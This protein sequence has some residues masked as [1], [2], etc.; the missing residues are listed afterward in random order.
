MKKC[1]SENHKRNRGAQTKE[2]ANYSNRLRCAELV[3]G[4]TVFGITEIALHIQL[5][6]AATEKF[7]SRAPPGVLKVAERKDLRS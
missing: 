6:S 3:F 7:Y 4:I 1:R 5:V 2:E